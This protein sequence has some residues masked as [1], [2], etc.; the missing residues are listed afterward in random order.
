[1]KK[2]TPILFIFFSITTLFSQDKNSGWKINEKQKT[3][4]VLNDV[5]VNEEALKM[6][7]KNIESVTVLKGDKGI[8]KYGDKGQNGV[9]EVTTKNI[10]K[11]ELS[12]LYL[13]YAETYLPNTKGKINTITG[14][15]VDCEEVPIKDAIIMNLNAKTVATSDSLGN[16]SI[17]A[18][19]NDV[20]QISKMG[21]EIKKVLITNEKKLDFSLK[22]VPVPEGNIY[23]KPVIYLYPIQK[24]EIT[25]TLN[26]NGKLLTTFPKYD[27]NWKVIAEPS[28]QLFDIKT[29][30]NYSS[31][32]WDADVQLP[33][34]HYQYKDGFVISKENLTA[35][36]IEKLEHIGLNNQETNEFI[37]FWLPILEQNEYNFIHFRINDACNEIAKLNVN[38]KPETSIRVYME[39]YGLEEFTTI[40]EQ[41]LTKTERK[42]FTLVE[43]GGAKVK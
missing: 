33:E 10:S 39:Y 18:R 15:I 17:E 2:V 35:F 6:D 20:L 4:F 5:L 26:V 34:E 13:L 31:L 25:L 38:P 30:R 3:L 7:P 12:K 36:F 8:L 32:F 28:G 11:K 16:Y 21:Y 19:K 23:R 1:M 27:K 29:K 24:T 9:I 14:K 22:A 43:W 37:Q 41:I 40:N 42:G